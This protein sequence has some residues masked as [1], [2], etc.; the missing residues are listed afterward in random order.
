MKKLALGI[1]W[2]FMVAPSAFSAVINVPGEVSSIQGAINTALDGDTVLVAPGIYYENI[3]FLGKGI[4]VTSNFIFDGDTATIS[5]TILDGSDPANPDS[6]SVVYFISGE[7][8]NAVITG[9]TVRN[10]TGTEVDEWR[11][12]GRCVCS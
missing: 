4:L 11:G 8:S 10:G 5:A 7:D 12:G 9:F 6:G 1:L 2:F 3:N